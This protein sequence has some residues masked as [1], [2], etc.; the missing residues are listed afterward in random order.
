MIARRLLLLAALSLAPG[1]APVTGQE[2]GSA[3]AE[4][5]LQEVH[6]TLEH[7]PAE[8]AMSLVRPLL[9]E[10]GSVS[11]EP[12]EPTLRIR[13]SLAALSRILPLLRSF[14]H[15]ARRLEIDVM[16]VRAGTA[17]TLPARRR[18]LPE[19]LRTRLARVL[20]YSDYHV[21]AEASLDGREGEE[22]SS[23][24]PGGLGLSF[25]LGTVLGGQRLRL[26]D[27]KVF[28]GVAAASG[29]QLLHTNLNLWRDQTFILGLT[30]DEE[31][32]SA[33]ILVMRWRLREAP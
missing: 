1:A 15:P 30:R 27:F 8:E 21:L 16:V 9:S 20:R 24:L 4:I 22:I 28:R 19:P 12:G 5:G 32:E 11:L 23:P 31:A 26:H 6:Y 17:E 3:A 29:R 18:P 10:R 33:F 2:E 13:D 25:Q 7:Q 14:D